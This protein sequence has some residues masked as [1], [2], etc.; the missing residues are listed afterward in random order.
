LSTGKI[1]VAAPAFAPKML[2]E[3]TKQ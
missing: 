2:A 3:N 1:G